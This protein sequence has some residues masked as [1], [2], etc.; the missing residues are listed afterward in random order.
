MTVL[1]CTIDLQFTISNKKKCILC[2]TVLNIFVQKRRTLT[3]FI[4]TPVLLGFSNLGRRHIIKSKYLFIPSHHPSP[5]RESLSVPLKVQS[6]AKPPVRQQT[7][8]DVSCT[9][10]GPCSS[11]H[12]QT[13]T[14]TDHRSDQYWK[15]KRSHPNPFFPGLFQLKA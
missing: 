8:S 4:T 11:H 12:T 9:Q 1:S 15:L 7:A 5:A 13:Q 3:C 14:L 10:S 6:P 2:E